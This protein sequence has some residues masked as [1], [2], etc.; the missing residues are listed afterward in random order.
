MLK[1]VSPARRP[2]RQR[3]RVPE[4][5]PLPLVPCLDATTVLEVCQEGILFLDAAGRIQIC[6]A[7]ASRILGLKESKM[8]GLRAVDPGVFDAVDEQL[9]PV[10][11]DQHPSQI[12]LRTGQPCLN[13]VQGLPKG[14]GRHLWV[15]INAIPLLKGGGMGWQK[16]LSS[17]FPTLPILNASKS[18]FWSRPRAASWRTPSHFQLPVCG[19]DDVTRI[20]S[21]LITPHPSSS[22]RLKIMNRANHGRL[23]PV[24][25]RYLSDP[26]TWSSRWVKAQTALA[27]PILD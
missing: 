18:D 8:L 10:P 24:L 11:P 17:A 9:H 15:K 25:L 3:L 6:N 19:A 21:M 16:V 7:S 13:A 22:L 2:T 4:G 23:E 27:P 1:P 14:G 12:A 20:T 5:E 26:S